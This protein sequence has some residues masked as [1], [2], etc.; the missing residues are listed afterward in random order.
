MDYKE[1][2]AM[3]NSI[4]AKKGRPT[5]KDVQWLLTHRLY[6]PQMGYP[7]LSDDVI[8]LKPDVKY[9]I[10]VS[11]I[12][13]DYHLKIGAEFSVPWGN[14][15]IK[16]IDKA[17][18]L[19]NKLRKTKEPIESLVVGLKSKKRKQFI[20]CSSLGKLGVTYCCQE[21]ITPGNH[22]IEVSSDGTNLAYAM[23]KEIISENKYIYSC[24]NPDRDDDFNALVFSLE[25]EER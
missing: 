14:G 17:F 16:V 21:Y 13:S 1:E 19:I 2:I 12:F 10:T 3:R 4:L 7:I 22:I 6:H 15:E 20:Y 24:K 9:L 8:D 5:S 23:K 11:E 25:I 18:S